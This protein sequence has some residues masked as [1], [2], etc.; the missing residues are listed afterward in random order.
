MPSSE[1]TDL[2][3]LV[4]IEEIKQLKARYFRCV[5]TKD[6]DGVANVFAED[7]VSGPHEGRPG[8]TTGN[9]AIAASISR[10]LEGVQSIHHG[11]TPEV[12]VT[13]PTTASGVWALEDQ[14]FGWPPGTPE[15]RR[16]GFGH[17]HETYVK[18]AAG[19]RIA[20]M[21]FERLR[22]DAELVGTSTRIDRPEPS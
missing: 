10:T 8:T 16:H 5:D 20:T 13:S 22:V 2:E 19:W 17:Y 3:R 14:M 6:F 21:R 15:G 4:A 7:A 12:S 1:V 18:T 11:H 9:I